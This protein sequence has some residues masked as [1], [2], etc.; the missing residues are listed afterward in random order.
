MRHLGCKPHHRELFL[1][2]LAG[3]FFHLCGI[4]QEPYPHVA[5]FRL[6][7]NQTLPEV[8]SAQEVIFTDTVSGI[9]SGEGIDRITAPPYAVIVGQRLELRDAATNATCFDRE[10][11]LDWEPGMATVSRA[12]PEI[13]WTVRHI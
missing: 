2:A 6:P 9:P 11:E 8:E 7:E 12:G 5:E 13:S 10:P 4:A 3:I 1:V